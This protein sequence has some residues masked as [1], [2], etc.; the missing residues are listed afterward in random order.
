MAVTDTL[1]PIGF[2][3]RKI[4]LTFH[5]ERRDGTQE[6]ININGSYRIRATI[7]NAGLSVGREVNLAIEGLPLDIM[8]RLSFIAGYA[9]DDGSKII[10]I[11]RSS[12]RVFA[13]VLDE[14]LA[15]IFDGNISEAYVDYSAAPDVTFRVR[16]QDLNRFSKTVNDQVG[17]REAMPPAAILSDLCVRNGLKFFDHGGWGSNDRI[18]VNYLNGDLLTQ[19]KRIVHPVKG[20]VTLEPAGGIDFNGKIST[21]IPVLHAWGRFA[22]RGEGVTP[23]TI[24]VI[25]AENGMIGYPRY[26]PVGCQIITIFRPELTFYSLVKLESRYL[27]AA[28]A[29][30]DENGFNQMRQF[31]IKDEN[32]QKSPWDGYWLV[33]AVNHDLSCEVPG[34]PWI[35]ELECMVSAFAQRFPVVR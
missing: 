29:S 3:R 13:G 8:N 32:A 23:D 7:S 22:T 18:K 28:F 16:A 10:G 12:V 11:S 24:P 15:T 1:N 17:Y 9:A 25:S 27:P 19:L 5:I 21:G 4:V 35:T 33:V 14:A 30:L 2:K 34:G 20:E 6:T 26:S 31:V